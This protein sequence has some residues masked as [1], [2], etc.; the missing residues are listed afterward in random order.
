MERFVLLKFSNFIPMTIIMTLFIHLKRYVY[1]AEKAGSTYLCFF[2][3]S[4]RPSLFVPSMK[5]HKCGKS[6][7]CICHI[8]LFCGSKCRKRIQVPSH[9]LCCKEEK[10]AWLQAYVPDRFLVPIKDVGTMSVGTILQH[11]N[12]APWNVRLLQ[13]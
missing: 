2:L 6:Y 13:Y 1:M 12:S 4:G 10:K 8:L 7:H 9:S 11:I 3:L 5:Y